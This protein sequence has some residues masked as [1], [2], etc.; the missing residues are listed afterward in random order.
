MLMRAKIGANIAN[1][2]V[3]I[4]IAGLGVY[5]Q[6]ESNNSDNKTEEYE[7]RITQLVKQSDS[8]INVIQKDSCR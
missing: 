8:L 5:A 1:A 4:L 3:I 2:I 7:S 6:F